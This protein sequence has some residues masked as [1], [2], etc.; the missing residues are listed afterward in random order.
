MVDVVL[1]LRAAGHRGPIHALSRHGRMHRPQRAFWPR[2][3]YELPKAGS[4]PVQ[5][6]RWLRNEVESATREGYDWRAVITALRSSTA[7]IWAGW[8]TAQRASFLRHARSL[9]DITA[10]RLRC[11]RDRCATQGRDAQVLSGRIV[12]LM[13][14]DGYAE[15][16]WRPR[17]HDE[18]QT[19]RDPCHQLY[20]AGRRL[21]ARAAAAGRTTP[22]A[23]ARPLGSVSRRKTTAAS[24][25]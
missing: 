16:R 1:T 20:R 15:M 6:M 4:S 11:T 23:G 17:G 8:S 25:S 3:I 18:T 7:T 14:A 22:S 10:W 2:P 24:S 13:A 21:R 19:L 9:W 12:S 5:C